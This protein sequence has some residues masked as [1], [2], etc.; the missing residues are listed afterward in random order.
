MRLVYGQLDAILEW[1]E[2]EIPIIVIENLAY[3]NQFIQDLFLQSNTNDDEPFYISDG[4]ARN[5]Q[6]KFETIINPFELNVNQNSILNNV[7]KIYEEL[8]QEKYFELTELTNNISNYLNS[9]ALSLPVNIQLDGNL[10]IKRL[11]KLFELTVIDESTNLMGRLM[12]YLQVNIQLGINDLFVF[13]NLKQFLGEEGLNALYEFL[14]NEEVKVLL[15][16]NQVLKGHNR[17]KYFVI[18]DDLC[19]IY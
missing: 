1:K 16:E 6:L 19:V 15:L 14:L 18:D 17:E 10:N 8:I 4:S 12:N 7:L 3:R 13:I 11:I 9:I 5:K 2:T